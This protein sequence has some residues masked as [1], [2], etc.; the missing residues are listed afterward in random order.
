[1]ITARRSVGQLVLLIASIV[2]VAIAVYLILVHYD[3]QNVPL[4]CSTR[5][6]VD[7]ENVLNSP[8]SV[9]PG[10][11]IPI[12]IPGL[13][14]FL[15]AAGLSFYSWNW[16]VSDRWLLLAEVIWGALGILTALYLVYVELV[17]LH[18]LCAWCT[19]LHV[20]ILAMFI[21]A[22]FQL[23]H[24]GTE[25]EWEEDDEVEA[26]LSVSSKQR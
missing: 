12:S 20:L 16:R 1:M 17:R 4:V 9:V 21:T 18:T 7:C 8:Y 6:F 19:A 2:G 10:T 15:V 23:Q 13:L 24:S 22:I 14:W 11:P 5:G 26:P 25:E 3:Q